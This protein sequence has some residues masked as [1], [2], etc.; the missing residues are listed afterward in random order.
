MTFPGGAEPDY[1][2]LEQICQRW[3]DWHCTI[4]KLFQLCESNK[5]DIGI[6]LPTRSPDKQRNDQQHKDNRSFSGFFSLSINDIKGGDSYRQ[7]SNA[8]FSMDIDTLYRHIE[9]TGE[10]VTITYP[11]PRKHEMSS[12]DL[13]ISRV[14]RDRFESK[15]KITFSNSK[16]S[17]QP[18][19]KP[20]SVREKNNLLLI[21]DTLCDIADID[22][23][24]P[25]KAANIMIK[26]ADISGKEL[27]SAHTIEK[28]L[29]EIQ[30][31]FNDQ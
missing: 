1:F 6:Y 31:G 30:P 20:L 26:A 7:L 17:Q 18:I 5:I 2:T 27:P 21:I 22:T 12:E 24:H 16:T 25:S 13:V 11:L 19:D 29:K 15:Y 8:P 3:S 9:D 10:L 4:A 28:R 14:E 23:T